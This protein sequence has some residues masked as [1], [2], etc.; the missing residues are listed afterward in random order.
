MC[1]GFSVQSTGCSVRRLD[2]K[3]R[4][5]ATAPSVTSPAGYPERD[6]EIHRETVTDKK[7]ETERDTQRDREAETER[8]TEETERQIVRTREG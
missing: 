3:T 8:Q 5:G 7:R 6:R 2:T 1:A 4:R